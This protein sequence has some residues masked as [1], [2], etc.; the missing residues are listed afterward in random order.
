MSKNP[1]NQP[2]PVN[3]TSLNIEKPRQSRRLLKTFYIDYNKEKISKGKGKLEKKENN[4]KE[5]N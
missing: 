1:S 2:P 3:V 5:Y 4:N